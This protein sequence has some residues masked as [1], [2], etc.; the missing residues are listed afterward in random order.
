METG[1]SAYE[2]SAWIYPVRVDEYVMK[3]KTLRMRLPTL[4]Q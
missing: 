2:N 3:E 4:T 1:K